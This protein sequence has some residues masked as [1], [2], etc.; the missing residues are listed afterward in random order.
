MENRTM[1]KKLKLTQTLRNCNHKHSKFVK[2]HNFLYPNLFSFWLFRQQIGFSR[3]LFLFYRLL[4][5]PD[6]CTSVRLQRD[7]ARQQQQSLSQPLTHVTLTC[8][9]SLVRSQWGSHFRDQLKSIKSKCIIY[10]CKRNIH[11]NWG[12]WKSKWLWCQ[13]FI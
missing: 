2:A 10:Q 9:K 6:I 3:W 8:L 7:A 4:F 12:L 5:S 13:T 11:S 1:T